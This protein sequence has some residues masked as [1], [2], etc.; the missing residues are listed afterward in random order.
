MADNITLNTGTGGSVLATDEVGTDHYQR[1]KLTDGTA[2]SST[3]IASGN[4][5]STNALRVTLSSDS[6][7]VVSVDD[8]GGSL[9][10]DNGGTFAVQATQAGAWTVAA[11]A[12]TN[13]N[14]SALALESGGN[15][16]TIAGDTT[17]IDGKFSAGAA[18]TDNF[19][20]PTTTGVGAF[21]MLWDGATWDR[22]P[23]S[24]A[25]G[26]TVNL[27]TNNDVTVTG[28]VTVDGSGVTQPVSAASLPLPTGAST[29][30]NQSTIIG[31]VDG[32]EGLLT[33]IDADT[34]SMTT[35]LATVAG[36]VAGTEMQVDLVGPIPA[37]TNNIGD[38]DIASIAAGTNVIGDVGISGAR[39]S[40]GTTMYRNIDVDETEDAVKASAGQVYWIHCVTIDATPVYLHFYNATV[41]SVTVGTTTP[42]LTFLVPTSGNSNGAGFTLSIPSGIAFSTAITVAAT[43]TVG[44]SAGPG[45][46]EVILNLGYA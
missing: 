46:N 45:A 30:A 35:N 6:T 3:V 34:S 26:V 40:G 21:G 9:T 11:N 27:G 22:M 37:G 41:A 36:A 7:G 31:H 15:L 20:N 17:S 18:L 2:D 5:V 23:G 28:S 19:A 33:T 24:S 14:T 4:G 44:G 10:V 32:I 12:G 13:L 43:T 38:V 25:D 8:N 29:A 39:T 42:D 1:V 16:A